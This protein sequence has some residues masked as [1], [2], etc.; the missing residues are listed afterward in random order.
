MAPTTPATRTRISALTLLILGQ[1]KLTSFLLIQRQF[2]NTHTVLYLSAVVG[3]SAAVH[4]VERHQFCRSDGGRRHVYS[5]TTYIGSRVLII[6]SQTG[7]RP[8]VKIFFRLVSAS[9]RF[10][11]SVSEAC[12]SGWGWDGAI[13]LTICSDMLTA[14]SSDSPTSTLALAARARS[15]VPYRTVLLYPYR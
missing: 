6:A 14:C 15:L 13:L 11:L 3:G 1:Y 9:L 7:L 8:A 10:A 5:N 4:T 12:C 2:V